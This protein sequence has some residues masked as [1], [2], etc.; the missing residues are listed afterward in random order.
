MKI[1][2]IVDFYVVL[3]EDGAYPLIWGKL[4]LSKS[5]VRIYW[6]K[7][8]MTIGIHHNWHKVPFA[9]FVKSFGGTN[10][11]NDESEIDQSFSSEGIY[12]NESNE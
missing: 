2:T 11:Y 8:F 7:G 4:W 1:F 10:E 3:E 12:I 9:N 5:H 6:G